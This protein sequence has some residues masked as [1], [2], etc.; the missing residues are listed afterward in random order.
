VTTQYPES[1]T[2]IGYSIGIL[3]LLTNC[4][5]TLISPELTVIKRVKNLYWHQLLEVGFISLSVRQATNIALYQIVRISKSQGSHRRL[6]LSL[7]EEVWSVAGRGH[8]LEGST[9]DKYNVITQ[10]IHECMGT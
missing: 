2:R 6:H 4:S 8:P 7:A 9:A 1:D 10:D 3:F 5:I